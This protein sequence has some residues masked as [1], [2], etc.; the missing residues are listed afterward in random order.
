MANK[1]FKGRPGSDFIGVNCTFFCHD[2][3]GRLLMHKRSQNCRDEV[4]RWDCG[5][6]AMEFGET[7][8]QT[9]RR[10]IKEEYGTKPIK[11][12]YCGFDNVIRHNK[13]RQTHWIAVIFAVQVDPKKV[14]NLEPHK[15]EQLGWFSSKKLPHPL[16]SMFIS[17]LRKVQLAG[18]KI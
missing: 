9:V 17:H 3:K 7:F 2:G 13:S 10:E 18:V 1:I 15:L 12:K 6:G 16:H 5:A 14:K 8:E 4:G 11:I